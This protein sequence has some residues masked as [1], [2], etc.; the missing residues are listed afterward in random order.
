M[1]LN[2]LKNEFPP[3][4]EEIKTKINLELKNQLRKENLSMKKHSKYSF[5]K[6]ATAITAS[7][8]ALAICVASPKLNDKNNPHIPSD[9]VNVTE[10]DRLAPNNFSIVSYDVN[11]SAGELISSDNDD[12]LL[13]FS[14]QGCGSPSYIGTLFKINGDNIAHV[15]MSIDKN[16]FYSLERKVNLSDTEADEVIP[17]TYDYSKEDYAQYGD[18]GNWTVDHMVSIGNVIDTDYD[19]D[20]YY[21]FYIP[22]EEIDKIEASD[23]DDI[24]KEFYEAC[25]TFDDAN[26]NITIT[27]TDG[28]QMS[29][30]YKL[31]AG[32]LKLDIDE[33]G[34]ILGRLREF[35]A[36]D[37]PYVYGILGEL[38][39]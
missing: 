5:V 30:S 24:K 25:E 15:Y 37:E 35:A 9:T 13:T 29:R 7:A 22:Q 2:N 19:A 38:Q 6:M 1:N 18:F 33:N 12:K 28:S 4:P 39:E 31:K 34:H 8:A 23:L 3:I 20:A 11:D 16:G 10:A 14:D 21:G 27:Y 26:L 32:K 17:K 36:D